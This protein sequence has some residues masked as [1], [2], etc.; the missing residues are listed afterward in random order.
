MKNYKNII[1]LATGSLI[2]AFGACKKYEQFPVDK[3]PVSLVFDKNDSLGSNAH[4][5]LNSI[6]AVMRNGHNAIGSDYLDAASDDAV[7]SAENSTNEVT[8]LST[9]TYNSYTLPTDEN[10][11]SGS[12]SYW[13]GI[14]MANEFVSNIDIVPVQQT[15]NG[16]SMKYAWKAEARFLRAY[17][18]FELIKRFGGVPLLGDKVYSLTDN[19]ALPRNTFADCVK[20]IVSECDAI[21]G[22]LL[23]SPLISPNA[24]YGR[25]TQGTAMALKAR[26]LLYAASPLF[27]GGN[28]D[29]ANDL[30][31]YTDFSVDRWAQAATAAK[32]VMNLNAYSLLPAYK[33]IF[34]TQ[35]NAEI[36]FI[37]QGNNNN[38]IE[39]NN[40]PVG[41]PGAN[42]L[43]RTSPTQNLVD[44]YPMNNG[45]PITDVTSGYNSDSPYANRDPRLTYNILY[46]TA[47]WL[48]TPLQTYEGGQS[49]PNIGQQ[50]TLTSYYMRKFMGNFEDVTAYAAHNEDWIMFRYA[51]ILLNYAEA[52]NETMASPN[53]DVYNQ[54]I[55]LRKRAGI[56]AGTDGMYGLKTGL[57]QADMRKVIQNERR[58]EM[59]FEENRFFDIRRWKIAE[60]VMNQP[61]TGSTIFKSGF[62][63]TYNTVNVLATKFVAPKMYLYPIPYDE[64]L[65]NPNMKQNPGW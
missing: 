50:Q 52:T 56:A 28:I 38:A 10:V 62:G 2:L 61:M 15:Y 30:T 59:A 45:L 47:Q 25:V 8:I 5:Y 14:R 63:Y 20:Y 65:K 19:I 18:Y 36:I 1:W 11:W 42:G 24:Y 48:S 46:N 39:S 17:F 29:A 27:N 44:A 12:K 34:L 49:K 21:K 57:N 9:A 6:Y 55:A 51:E 23:T 40:G 16:V 54:I 60:T 35:N 41:F 26:V 31:G 4:Q 43:G 53:T 32:D 13:S 58:I 64:V 33:D 37:R 7:S 3:V 22:S